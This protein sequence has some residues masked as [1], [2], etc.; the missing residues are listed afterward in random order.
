[1]AN[2]T[3]APTASLSTSD[4]ISVGKSQT[5]LGA[6][7]KVLFD[8]VVALSTTL[9]L[10]PLL[11]QMANPIWAI[12]LASGDGAKLKFD[13]AATFTVKA[14][15]MMLLELTPNSPGPSGLLDLE[16]ETNSVAVQRI[17]FMAVGDPD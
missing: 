17:R 6:N 4:G 7:A 12:M 5:G 13:G 8:D 16:I 3:Y 15:K 1:M 14:F 10:A 2:F 9:D 11:L